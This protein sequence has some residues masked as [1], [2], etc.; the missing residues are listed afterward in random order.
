MNPLIYI[1]ISLIASTLI[2]NNQL[3]ES[4]RHKIAPYAT[5]CQ[6]E[7]CQLR[8]THLALYSYIKKVLNDNFDIGGKEILPL[9]KSIETLKKRF[10]LD[11]IN[12]NSNLNGTNVV[13]ALLSNETLVQAVKIFNSPEGRSMTDFYRSSVNGRDQILSC[14]QYRVEEIER[15]AKKLDDNKQLNWLFSKIHQNFVKKS[16]KKCLKCSCNSIDLSMSRLDSTLSKQKPSSNS[17]NQLFG[18]SS[19][20]NGTNS[21]SSVENI[22]RREFEQEELRLCQFFKQTNET[23]CIITGRELNEIELINN[24]TFLETSL[25]SYNQNVLLK[26]NITSLANESITVN[27]ELARESV[28]QQCKQIKS[29]LDYNL[30]AL[31]WYKHE[32]LIGG[33]KLNS[34]TFWCPSLYY[35]LQIDRLCEELGKTAQTTTTKFSYEVIKSNTL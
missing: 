27:L 9:L 22:N 17:Y 30:Y 24:R 34:R 10:E 32:G 35:W 3:V 7:E 31:K 28:D 23:D 5:K 12:A 29:L 19:D 25:K 2:A 33:E 13:R 16:A 21:L 18:E 11:Q 26:E 4:R 20:D 14:S 15:F 8:P 1:S 6:A